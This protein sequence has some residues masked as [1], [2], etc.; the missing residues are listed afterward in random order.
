[1]AAEMARYDRMCLAITECHEIDEAKDLHRTQ[2]GLARAKAGGKI[3]GRRPKTTE[4]QRIEIKRRC[5]SGESISALARNFDV[6][7]ATVLSI[8]REP[9]RSAECMPPPMPMPT[10]T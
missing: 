1:M 7:R 2:A 10:A 3:L 6:S 5:A 8:V 9:P 4:Q